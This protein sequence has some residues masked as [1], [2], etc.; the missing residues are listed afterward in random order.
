MNDLSAYLTSVVAQPAYTAAVDALASAV[1]TDIQ[2]EFLNDPEGYVQSAF[3]NPAVPSWFTAI[4][5]SVQAY[6]SS[7]GQ[8]E[9][10]ILSKDAKGPAPTNAVRVAG[11][12]MAAGGA[13]LVLL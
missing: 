7:M 11:A 10:S 3:T 4:P 5:T 6:F 12:V 9:A 13:A 2:S 1:P 8:A